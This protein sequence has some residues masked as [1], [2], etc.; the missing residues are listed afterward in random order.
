LAG[1]CYGYF[2]YVLVEIFECG[3]FGGVVLRVVM[4]TRLSVVIS[5]FD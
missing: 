4:S 3:Y 5:G 1:W 2:E